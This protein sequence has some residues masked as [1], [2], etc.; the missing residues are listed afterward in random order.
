VYGYPAQ[1]HVFRGNGTLYDVGKYDRHLAVVQFGNKEVGDFNLG[2][3]VDE[4]DDLVISGGIVKGDSIDGIPALLVDSLGKGKIVLFS[5]NPMH[6]HLNHHDHGFVYNA[7]M[8]WNDLPIP[9]R[10]GVDHATSG[11]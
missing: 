10:P 8:H 5:W 9:Q 4:P 3:K 7:L 1:T 11:E 2:D 6:R